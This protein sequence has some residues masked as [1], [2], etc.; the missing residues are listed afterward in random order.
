[1]DQWF[2]I[3][4]DFLYLLFL[5]GGNIFQSFFSHWIESWEQA[6]QVNRNDKL[7]ERIKECYTNIM[8]NNL[9]SKIK[10]NYQVG[11]AV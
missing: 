10:P 2:S 8:M 5:H 3:T 4:N 6:L 9:L 1:M 11:V 7:L